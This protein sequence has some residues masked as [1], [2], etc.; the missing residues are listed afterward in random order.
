MALIQKLNSL[1]KKILNFGSASKLQKTK[2]LDYKPLLLISFFTLFSIIYFS[3]E[4][5]LKKKNELSEKNLKNI[6]KS[7]DF[8]NLKNYFFSKINSP[9]EEIKYSI[10]NND[11]IEKILKSY[12]IK[13]DDI[14]SISVK[15]KN[16]KLTNIY[17]GRELTLIYKKMGDGSNTV[18]N[19]FFPINNTIRY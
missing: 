10:K 17:S 14:N 19:L 4:N 3:I 16:Q 13:S 6:A 11:S 18:V 2:I 15:L 7:E 9:Y 12:S 5:V 8:S 1:F